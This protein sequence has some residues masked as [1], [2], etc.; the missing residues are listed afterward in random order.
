MR[1]NEARWF[2]LASYRPLLSL[3][4]FVFEGLSS[5]CSQYTGFITDWEYGTPHS[6]VMSSLGGTDYTCV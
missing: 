1:A 5:G 2:E 3:L 6:R 4:G